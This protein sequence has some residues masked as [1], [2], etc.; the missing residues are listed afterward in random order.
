VTGASTA[1]LAVVLVDARNGVVEQ[2][3][4]HAFIASL[5]GIPRLVVAVNKMDLVGFSEEAFDAVV[6]DFPALDVAGVTFIPVS[7]LRGDNVV[8]RSSRTP[9]YAGPLLLAE[10]EAVELEHDR[11]DGPLRLPVQYVIRDGAGDYRGYA[12]RV[13]GGVVRPGDAVTVLPAG[14]L[15]TIAAI[16]SLGGTL[17][18]AH[19]GDSVTIRL[20]DDLDVSRG[21]L[22]AAAGAGPEPRRE[23]DADVCWMADAP[24]RGGGR[25]LV[26]HTTR[27]T[28]AVVDAVVDRVDVATLGRD[29]G[30]TQLALNDIGRV[31]LRTAQPLAAD[32]YRCNRATGSFIV[33]DEASNETVGAGM[34]R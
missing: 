2:T 18:V 26:K 29:T 12:G 14:R 13:A 25:Y 19:A 7:A 8:E 23:L 33:I 11:D 1:D 9:W 27:T 16:D 3:R 4:R 10:L 24:L 30:A 34:V 28:R 17:D 22:I 32:P 6:R 20:T 21:D 5:L 31:R 15:T